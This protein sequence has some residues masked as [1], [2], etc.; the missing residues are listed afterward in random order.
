MGQMGFCK[1]LRFAAFFGEILRFA[2]GFLSTQHEGKSRKSATLRAPS[3]GE[4]AGWPV[5][6]GKKHP[7]RRVHLAVGSG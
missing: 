3:Y 4:M 5:G 1:N 7:T 2:C 6:S